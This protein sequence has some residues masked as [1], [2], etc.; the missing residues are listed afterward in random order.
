MANREKPCYFS[1]VDWHGPKADGCVVVGIYCIRCNGDGWLRLTVLGLLMPMPMLILVLV[2]M[3][4]SAGVGAAG[5]RL[6]RGGSQKH[7]SRR[8]EAGSSQVRA[9]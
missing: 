9:F 1:F 8:E 6:P 2:L 4:T 3:G 5:D 7:P